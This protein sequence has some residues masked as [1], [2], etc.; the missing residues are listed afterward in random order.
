MRNNQEKPF[1]ILRRELLNRLDM[2]GQMSDE[3][4][5]ELIDDLVLGWS[6]GSPLSLLQKESL[7]KDL[8]Y[9]VR[10]LDVLQDLIDD[11]EVTEIMVNGRDRIYV[12]K[13][14]VISRY[15]KSFLNEERLSDIILQIA[16][17]C[18]KVV[19][20]QSPI[21]DARL[22]NGDRV[23][24][25]L[26]PVAVDGPVLTIRRFPKEAITMNL[27]LAYD[28][29]TKEAA[30]FLETAVKAR[31]SILIS[32][33]TSTGKTTFLNALSFF[34][35]ESERVVTIEDTAELQ[36]QDLPNLVRL[37]ARSAN[38][39]ETKEINIRDLIRTSLRMRPSRIII[40][41]VRG[42]EAADFLTCL[43][44]GHAGSLGSVHANSAADVSSRLEMMVRMAA[45][46]P[47]PVI[48][49]QIASGVDIIVHL[50]RDEAG[51]RKVEEIAEVEGLADGEVAVRSIFRRKNRVLVRCGDLS[52]REK[53]DAYLTFAGEQEKS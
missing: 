36:L 19:N 18:N 12:E 51:K 13:G 7:R 24:I 22:A 5:L 27:L 38:Y 39:E 50:Y 21:A 8:Y 33:G 47:I 28:S 14:G 44:T 6:G 23:N 45:D 17:R 11:P 42:G 41:E 2:Y 53:W 49:A 43:N 25:V 3:E 4:I 26:P 15:G 1:E 31:Y 9:S 37:E 29:L 10:K 32:G 35:P 40:G 48:R 34:I 46:L 16:G 20:E 52:R 30:S